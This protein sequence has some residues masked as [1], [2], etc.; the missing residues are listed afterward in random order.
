MIAS[1][2]VAPLAH[3]SRMNQT[4]QARTIAAALI[5][6]LRSPRYAAPVLRP[7]ADELEARK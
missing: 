5:A 1:L 7:I 2:R 6:A 3:G 4:G